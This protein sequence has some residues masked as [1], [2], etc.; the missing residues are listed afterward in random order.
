MIWGFVFKDTFRLEGYSGFS[1]YDDP[2]PII[3]V[4]NSSTKT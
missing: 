1:L 2:F 3:Y 4:N